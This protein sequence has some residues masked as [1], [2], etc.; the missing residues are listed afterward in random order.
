MSRPSRTKV[1]DELPLESDT[2]WV[3]QSCDE[4]FET[5]QEYDEHVGD[6]RRT[7]HIKKVRS[8]GGQR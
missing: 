3:C 8:E 2:L 6:D 1:I 4:Y 7:A 5:E